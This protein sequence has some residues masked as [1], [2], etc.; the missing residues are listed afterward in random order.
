[1]R[2]P[3]TSLVD[4]GQLIT[5]KSLRSS[6]QLLLL[7]IEEAGGYGRARVGTS[8]NKGS[9]VLHHG[10]EGKGMLQQLVREE[11]YIGS[12]GGRGAGGGGTGA[13]GGVVLE[14]EGEAVVP[15]VV[16]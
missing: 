5:D 10:A 9:K 15:E 13:G 7:L 14:G 2:K 16:S 8:S 1:M 6:R 4:S 3:S 11:G 12:R